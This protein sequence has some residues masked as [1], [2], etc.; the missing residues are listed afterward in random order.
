MADREY[1]QPRFAPPPGAT[2]IALVRH[3]ESAP[4]R[5]GEPFPL[6][7]GHGDPP[8]APEGHDQAERLAHRLAPEPVDA[9]YVSPLRRTR[10]TAD[11]FLTRS[12]LEASVLSDLREVHLGEWEGGVFRRHVA[13]GHPVARE[14]V[15]RRRWDVIPGAEPHDEFTD[16]VAGALRHLHHRHPDQRVVAFAHGGVIGAAVAHV[17]GGDAFTFAA[18]DNA[19]ITHLVVLDDWWHLRS[20]NDTS[21][22][23]PLF[24]PSSPAPR[25]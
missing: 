16:R 5:V 1:R 18:V 17:V 6:L 23:G 12:G 11:P 22:L 15:E 7:D 9:V 21:H 13:D 24:A 25:G 19:S 2:E 20:Y 8:L 3:G 10:Q 4:A 14:M